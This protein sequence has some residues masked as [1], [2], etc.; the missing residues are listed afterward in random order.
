MENQIPDQ[1]GIPAK[2]IIR[3]TLIILSIIL[4]LLIAFTFVFAIKTRYFYSRKFGS[5]PLL[6]IWKT[7]KNEKLGF[8]FK[9][10]GNFIINETSEGVSISEPARNPGGI[11]IA[12]G[13]H[14]FKMSVYFAGETLLSNVKNPTNLKG[15][16]RG[17]IGRMQAYSTS[18]GD[19]ACISS[20]IIF[21]GIQNPP[22]NKI[23][24]I[25]SDAPNRGGDVLFKKIL[26]TIKFNKNKE[27]A[28]GKFCGGSTGV[29]CPPGYF[30][31]K[32]FDFVDSEG[33]C[34]VAEKNKGSAADFDQWTEYENKKFLYSIK[35]RPKENLKSSTCGENPEIWGGDEWFI[36]EDENET[37]SQSAC[38]DPNSFADLSIHAVEGNRVEYENIFQGYPGYNF[39]FRDYVLVGGKYGGHNVEYTYTG[40]DISG[41]MPKKL[42]QALFLKDGF[43]YYITLSNFNLLSTYDD[44]IKTFKAIGDEGMHEG[45]VCGGSFILV[46]LYR[47][48]D[49]GISG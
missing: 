18:T 33:I 9:Y 19:R 16:S 25:W 37:A 30:C 21:D 12:F 6:G 44:I 45:D 7:Y 29:G 13:C 1:Q 27:T 8:S 24:L 14:D 42:K 31:Q 47:F 36:L 39:T 11:Q 32:A 26:S 23:L 43:T 34:V 28:D 22:T 46:L 49:F 10:P 3:P 5:I 35:Y 17:E 40:N 15:Y 41:R 20:S 4:L 2:K 48:D 38:F